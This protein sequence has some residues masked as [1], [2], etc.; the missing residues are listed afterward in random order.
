[1]C[2]QRS[3]VFLCALVFISVCFCCVQIE[4][5]TSTSNSVVVFEWH[6]SVI[7]ARS[8]TVQNLKKK[9]QG[10]KLRMV[11]AMREQETETERELTASQRGNDHKSNHAVRVTETQSIQYIDSNGGIN[12]IKCLLLSCSHS[13]VRSFASS[14]D[15]S[16]R[17]LETENCT[18]FNCA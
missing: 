18:I 1:M 7:Y 9:Q 13:L 4:V 3:T 11:K 15:D 17:W 16:I 14:P 8:C 2:S 6:F 10:S 12:Q 5:I